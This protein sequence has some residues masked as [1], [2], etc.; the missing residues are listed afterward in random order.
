MSKPNQN[1]T[2][3]NCTPNR[4]AQ[5]PLQLSIMQETNE[6][7]VETENRV[8]ESVMSTYKKINENAA[9]LPLQS[10]LCQ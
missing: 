9:Q 4:T 3:V 2:I 5:L 7:V 1:K 8:K 10:P 6:S